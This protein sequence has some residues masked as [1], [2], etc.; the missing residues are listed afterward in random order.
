MGAG[1]AGEAGGRGRNMNIIAIDIGNTNITVGLFLKDEEKFIKSMPGGEEEELRACL[2]EAWEKVPVVAGSKEHK[3]NGVLAVSSVKPVWLEVVRGIAKETLGEDL[4]VVGQEIGL[5]MN[6][7]V[8]EPGKVGTD[9]VVAASAAFDVVGAAVVVVDVGTAITI[10]LVDDNGIF[11]GG[12]IMPG[13]QTAAAALKEHTALLPEIKVSKPAEPFG[14]NTAEAINCG[15]YY[16][17]VGAIEE[18]IRRYAERI[19]RWPQ[20]VITGSGAKLIADDCGFIDSYVPNLVVK[21]IVLAY[22]KHVAE[23]EE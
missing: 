23:K 22:Q 11:Q 15:V 17:V 20:T 1:A 2:R 18:I 13:L 5:P 21:G 12:A 16:S 4:Y 3:H 6:M 9:R 7:W 8:D 19:G 10:D 14:K